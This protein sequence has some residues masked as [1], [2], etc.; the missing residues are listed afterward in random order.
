MQHVRTLYMPRHGAAVKCP[1]TRGGCRA[2]MFMKATRSSRVCADERSPSGDDRK[3][4]E[5][6]AHFAHCMFQVA[7]QAPCSDLTRKQP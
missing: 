4:Q 1:R 6:Q 2:A 5:I 3:I 7:H